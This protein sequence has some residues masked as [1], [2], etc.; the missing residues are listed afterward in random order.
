M[1]LTFQSCYFQNM[2]LVECE[3]G[4]TARV[5]SA[6]IENNFDLDNISFQNCVS[7]SVE[8]ASTMVGK[9]NSLA[10]RF[11]D[12]NSEILIS[13]CPCHLAYITTSHANDGFSEVL[14]VNVENICVNIF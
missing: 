9:R 5:I 13:G 3:H 10:S 6:A 12:N 2:S 11:K 8:N 7:F 1:M 14:G 4:A